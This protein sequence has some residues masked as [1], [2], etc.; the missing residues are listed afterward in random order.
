MASGNPITL[1][2][3]KFL[4]ESVE[5]DVER[6]VFFYTEVNGYRLPV[7]HRL[8]AALNA[9]WST[10]RVQHA[11]QIGVY[12]AYN[13]HNT[14]AINFTQDAEDPYVTYAEQTYLFGVIPAI[15]FNF[16]F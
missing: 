11:A 8:D 14:W 1:A 5:G 15:T 10:G 3:V 2:G 6:D 4:H 7:Y 9:T 16:N 13:R 12:N